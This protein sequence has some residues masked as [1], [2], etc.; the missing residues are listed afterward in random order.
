LK[1]VELRD[2][3]AEPIAG[4]RPRGDDRRDPAECRHFPAFHRD[5][6]L[7]PDRSS[8]P[9][10]K[11]SRSTATRRPQH[12]RRSAT[13]RRANRALRISSLS[14]P[15]AV[16]TASRTQAVD[17]TSSAKGRQAQRGVMRCGIIS[18]SAPLPPRWPLPAASH[19][20]TPAHDRR[21][22]SSCS[23]LFFNRH[24]VAAFSLAHSAR[25]PLLVALL[26]HVEAAVRHFSVTGISQLT[27]SHSG[28]A[29]SRNLA[30][31]CGCF[32]SPS[33]ARRT[34]A[35]RLMR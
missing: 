3:L 13:R 19:P 31:F 34:G 17:H 12:A 24:L 32:F 23:S 5:V 1:P 18:T 30:V 20:A 27:K 14:T 10:E 9:R 26:H 33:G 4:Q 2:R 16:G 7:R 15:T 28:N 29:R 21:Y 35:G 8:T 25:A 6:L 22:H 11:P